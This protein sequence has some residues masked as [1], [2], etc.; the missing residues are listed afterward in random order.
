MPASPNPTT[1]IKEYD[2]RTAA[3]VVGGEKIEDI[4]S[5]SFT[6][7]KDHDAVK[8]IDQSGIWV[9]ATPELTGT[10][11]MHA[12]S[13]SVP[14]LEAMWKN[15]QVFDITAQPAETESRGPITFVG[16]MITDLDTGD[17]ETDEMPTVTA[18]W[19]GFDMG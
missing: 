19:E 13:P 12:T 18:D 4:D 9:I 6:Q 5:F 3:I 15:E 17:Y 7:T 14:V 11:S 10:V 2:A 16:C 1:T 8:T